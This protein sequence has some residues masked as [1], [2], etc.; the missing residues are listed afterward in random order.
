MESQSTGGA[1]ARR[2][3][4]PAV[5]PAPQIVPVLGS[6]RAQDRLQGR[7]APAAL[8]LRARQDRAEPHHRGL[9]QA[10]ARARAGD[11]A[12]AV[13]RPAAVHGEVGGAVVARRDVQRQSSWAGP[14]SPESGALLG[15]LGAASLSGGADRLAGRADPRLSGAAPAVRRRTVARNRRCGDRPALT[16][17]AVLLAAGGVIAAAL[18][19]GLYAAPVVLLVRQALAGA[20]RAARARSNGI[21]RDC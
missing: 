6:E 7:Q 8:R 14:G 15:A 20:Q 4:P 18:F 2:C 19:A 12:G 10:A 9:D 1:G 13:S 21:R 5:F 17:S 11:Q 16:A 3:D